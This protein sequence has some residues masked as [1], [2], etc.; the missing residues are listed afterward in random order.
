MGRKKNAKNFETEEERHYLSWG[1]GNTNPNNKNVIM[2]QMRTAILHYS[3]GTNKCC[4]EGCN[5]PIESLTLEHED[6]DRIVMNKDLGIHANTGGY[7][8]ARRLIF[9]GFPDINLTVKC[10]Y[11][12]SMNRHPKNKVGP[13]SK[14]MINQKIKAFAIYGYIDNID[15]MTW[16]HSLND[17][18]IHRKYLRVKYNMKL[19]NNNPTGT[20]FNS[21]M[22]R[23]NKLGLPNWQGL[24]LQHANKNHVGGKSIRGTVDYSLFWTEDSYKPFRDS[25]TEEQKEKMKNDVQN[26]Y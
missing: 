4:I 19:Y 23:E 3:N 5:A 24:I 12:N 6:F 7:K 21:Y 10:M 18:T 26:I 15:G 17:G 8:L 2:W 9:L 25:L 20:A 13:S 11:H 1:D 14:Y 16:E 22:I